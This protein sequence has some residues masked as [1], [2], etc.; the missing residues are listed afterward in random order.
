MT[1]PVKGYFSTSTFQSFDGS[2]FTTSGIDVKFPYGLSVYTGCGTNFKG[3]DIGVFDIKESN[4]YNPN[5]VINH[6]ARIR[7]KYNDNTLTTQVRVSPLSVNVPVG[8]KTSIYVN[9]HYV[10][11]YNY[12]EKTW[13]NGAGIFAGVTQKIGKDMTIS[14]EGQRYNLQNISDNN[15]SNWSFNAIFSVKL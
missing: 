1:E 13:T 15:G 2:N 5:G 12:K 3:N 6:N 9:P 7:T 14:F 4:K 11:Q 10:G 8:D